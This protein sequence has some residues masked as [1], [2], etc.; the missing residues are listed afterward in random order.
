MKRILAQERT[1][2]LWIK[3]NS[4]LESLGLYIY[5]KA[6][7]DVQVTVLTAE[8]VK[9]KAASDTK[10]VQT[11]LGEVRR[12]EV[13]HHEQGWRITGCCRPLKLLGDGLGT[14]A[15]SSRSIPLLAQRLEDIV[16]GRLTSFP[17]LFG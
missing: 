5:S 17:R 2:H 11:V 8:Y 13:K 16:A 15:N 3:I 12:C 9:R 7:H 10:K 4:A 1:V 6:S 14:L